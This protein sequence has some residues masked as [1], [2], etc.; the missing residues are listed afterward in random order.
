MLP[1][2][3]CLQKRTLIQVEFLQHEIERVCTAKTYGCHLLCTCVGWREV[4]LAARIDGFIDP[5]ALWS[6]ISPPLGI[7]NMICY[8][9]I[10]LEVHV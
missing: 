8:D 9:E 10:E 5:H 2:L 3:S 4:K 6:K 7:L 1:I